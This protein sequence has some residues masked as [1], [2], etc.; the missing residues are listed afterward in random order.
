MVLV[1]TATVFSTCRQEE[2]LLARAVDFLYGRSAVL[3]VMLSGV[4]VALAS[5]R[6]RASGSAAGLGR[7][8][9]MLMRRGLVL[10]A[11]GWVFRR[12]WTPD[13]LHFYGAYLT[14][15]AMLLSASSRL[16]WGTAAVLLT[17]AALLFVTAGGDPS[18]RPWLDERIGLFAALDDLAVSGFY[19]V[20]PWLAFLLVGLWAG[21]S[22]LF[23]RGVPRW[24]TGAAAAAVFLA[25]EA[26]S[27]WQPEVAAGAEPGLWG[28]VSAMEVFPVSP[29]FALSAG[30]LALTVIV[31][32]AAAMDHPLFSRLLAPLRFT[33]RLTLS[34]YVGHI[35]LWVGVHGTLAS[36]GVEDVPLGHAAM[37]AFAVCLASAMI[38][39]L[40]CRRFGRGPLEALLRRLSFSGT[41]LPGR[42]WGA[43]PSAPLEPEVVPHDG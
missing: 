10:F 29:L 23:Q 32:S 37:G 12:V 24:R 25:S 26:V 9:W 39:P 17:T 36:R 5:R 43:S 7:V 6:A 14:A 11:M 15:A 40:W 16:L 35:L 4:G 27:Q 38:A 20:F 41:P 18:L 21:R 19:P 2:G 42:P 28:L 13:I 1:N 31:W 30:A 33:G 8:R 34:L 22:G 3:F